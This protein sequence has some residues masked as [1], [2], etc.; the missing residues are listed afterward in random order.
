MGATGIERSDPN[1]S[2]HLEGH[3]SWSTGARTR[4]AQLVPD[5]TYGIR[6]TS[7]SAFVRSSNGPCR[8]RTYDQGIK[9]SARRVPLST[10]L[11]RNPSNRACSARVNPGLTT[12]DAAESVDRLLTLW[13]QRSSSAGGVRERRG[14]LAADHRRCLVDELIVLEG[15]H[16]GSPSAPDQLWLVRGCFSPSP[17]WDRRVRCN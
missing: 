16:R 12:P 3:I 2:H 5:D 4:R 13:R 15:R 6:N 8:T 1:L 11:S 17:T 9:R 14:R 10:S 7:R